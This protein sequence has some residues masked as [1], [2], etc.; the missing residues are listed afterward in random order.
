ML[1]SGRN[2]LLALDIKVSMATL[3]IGT[4]AMMA[5][6]F[7]MNLTSGLES[8]PYAFVAITSS[9]ALAALLVYLYSSR[10]LRK[11]R[12]VA[13]VGR[14]TSLPESV[15]EA[16]ERFVRERAERER[17][18]LAAALA[19]E[20]VATAAEVVADAGAPGLHPIPDYETRWGEVRSHLK[21]RQ[22]FWDRLFR[23][24]SMRR[25]LLGMGPG[26]VVPGTAPPHRALVVERARG[27]N[28][29]SP[30]PS[31]PT[32]SPTRP[33]PPRIDSPTLSRSTR[34]EA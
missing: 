27:A 15:R 33:T 32:L 5:G 21:S 26:P 7:G 18:D 10:V 1:D 29:A 4:G 20:R 23:R 14:P 24:N 12:H 34:T 8:A 9:T 6:L 25:V 17:A 13:L 22:S 3:G 16:K 30:H 31:S 19:A 28:P 11:V 2:A